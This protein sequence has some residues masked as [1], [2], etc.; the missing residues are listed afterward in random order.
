MNYRVRPGYTFGQFDQHPAGTLVELT[1]AEALGFLD[2][3]EPV[4]AEP[5][6]ELNSSDDAGE[7]TPRKKT[8]RK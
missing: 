4:P 7:T 1:E 6:L 5:S 8:A 2:K 3:L